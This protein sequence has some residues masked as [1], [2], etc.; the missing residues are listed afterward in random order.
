MKKLLLVG[1]G[2]LILGAVAYYYVQSAR[3]TLVASPSKGALS[4]VTATGEPTFPSLMVDFD[5]KN[6]EPQ[7]GEFVVFGDGEKSA[8]GYTTPTNSRH[9]FHEPGTYTVKLEYKGA[10]LAETTVEVSPL[11]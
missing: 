11:P 6:Y 4:A 1:A 3:I 9:D 10:I 2:I 5:V 8:L 7:G